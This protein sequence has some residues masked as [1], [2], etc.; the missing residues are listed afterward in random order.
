ME[1]NKQATLESSIKEISNEELTQVTG[2]AAPLAIIA[3]RVAWFGA[4]AAVSWASSAIY[5]TAE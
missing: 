5:T 4:R 1:H 3:G 2:G